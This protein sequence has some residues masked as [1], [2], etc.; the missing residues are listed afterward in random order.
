MNKDIRNRPTV[1]CK[2]YARSDGSQVDC[3]NTLYE[4]GYSRDD[5]ANA[6]ETLRPI[7]RCTNCQAETPRISRNIR[8][9]S[10]KKYD[11]ID[12]LKAEWAE[13]EIKL[14][15]LLESGKIK[16]GALLVYGFSFNYHVE[17][18]RSKQKPTRWDLSYHASQARKDL[19]RAKQFITEN[20]ANNAA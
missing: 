16:S 2:G 3:G 8:P 10:L 17:A 1:I 11:V 20:E 15:N 19:E 12:A 18:L 6:L 14:H 4:M 13:T 7:W 5:A 9:L